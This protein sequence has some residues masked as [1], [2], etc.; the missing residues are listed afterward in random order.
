MPTNLIVA[1]ITAYI[2]TGSPCA[3]THYPT[4]HKTVAAPRSIP[5]GTRVYIE[6]VGYRIVEDRT[7][8]RFNGRWDL[9]VAS[10]EEALMWGKKDLKIWIIK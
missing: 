2:A 8:K 6:S 5:L 3:N 4:L 7:A 10:K 1:T 9:F